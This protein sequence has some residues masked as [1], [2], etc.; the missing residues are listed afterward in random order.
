MSKTLTQSRVRDLAASIRQGIQHCKKLGKA[1]GK[2]I[3][4]PG[5]CGWLQG[6]IENLVDELA[7]PEAR[8]LVT[9]AFDTDAEEEAA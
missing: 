4:Y 8:K 6:E 7:G 2:R 3:S 5:Y 1:E 9:E